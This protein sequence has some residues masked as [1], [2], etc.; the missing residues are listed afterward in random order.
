[1]HLG[2][3][4]TS[5]RKPGSEGQDDP[6]YVPVRYDSRN[7][8]SMSRLQSS[9]MSFLFFFLSGFCPSLLMIWQHYLNSLKPPILIAVID[10]PSRPDHDRRSRWRIPGVRG[11]RLQTPKPRHQPWSRTQM[12]ETRRRLAEHQTICP[13]WIKHRCNHWC[14]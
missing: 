9:S 10:S 1:M 6:I 4:R 13:I 5:R 2:L 8:R 11:S 3:R 12:G 7:F 14:G